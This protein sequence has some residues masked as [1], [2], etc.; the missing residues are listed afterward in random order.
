MVYT[1]LSILTKII[2]TALHT[3]MH[4]STITVFNKYVKQIFFYQLENDVCE[5]AYL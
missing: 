1:V 3:H 2:L 4:G 5:R